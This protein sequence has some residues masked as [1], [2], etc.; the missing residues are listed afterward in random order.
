MYLNFFYRGDVYSLQ[1]E[2]T[3]A[4]SDFTKSIEL[5]SEYDIEERELGAIYFLRG[6]ANTHTRNFQEAQSD[7]EQ[8]VKLDPDAPQ[9]RK[10]HNAAKRN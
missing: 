3:A 4:R 7:F 10:Y 1:E 9:Y 6:I 8:A 2:W 5:T